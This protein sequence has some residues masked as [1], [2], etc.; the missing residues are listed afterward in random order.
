MPDSF[1]P[2][3]KDSFL[4]DTQVSVIQKQDSFVADSFI[5]E[6]KTAQQQVNT[7]LL[8]SIK[9]IPRF[10]SPTAE[11]LSKQLTG[12]SFSEKLGFDKKAQIRIENYANEVFKRTGKPPNVT[13]AFLREIP[14]S[15][16]EQVVKFID[17]NYFDIATLVLLPKTVKE[18]GKIPIK[19][20]PISQIAQTPLGKGWKGSLK[21]YKAFQTSLKNL[22]LRPESKIFKGMPSNII[23]EPLAPPV[24]GIVPTILPE[25][26][27][28]SVGI[29]PKNIKLSKGEAIRQIGTEKYAPEIKI[30]LEKILNEHPEMVKRKTISHQAIQDMAN[31]LQ[32]TPIVKKLLSMPEGQLAA[33]SLKLRQ[34]EDALI[35]ATLESDLGDLGNN[36]RN[37]LKVRQTGAVVKTGTE[38]GRALEQQKMLVKSQQEIANLINQKI[39]Q[40]KKDPFFRGREG[41][42]LVAGLMELR[43]QTLSKEFD[44]SFFDKAYEFWLHNILSGVWTHTVNV[45]SNAAFAIAKPV[46]KGVAAA[47]DIPLSWFTGKREHYFSEI[48]QQIKGY[49]I[50]FN[51]KQKV[52][53]GVAL[54]SKYPMRAH[55]IGG[56]Q[57]ELVRIPSKL[58]SAEDNFS[59]R[60]IG[61]AENLGRAD[62]IARQEG[63]KG[64]EL[65]ARKNELLATIPENLKVQVNREQLYRTFQDSTGMGELLGKIPQKF[66]RW[67]MPFRNV[68]SSIITKS[69]ERTPLGFV[70]VGAKA[71]AMKSGY[72]QYELAMDLGNATLGTA[73]ATGVTWAYLKG[74]ITGAPPIN[75]AERDLFYAQ[76]KQP[77]S[78][79]VDG[80]Y[81]PYNRIEPYGT[82]AM[83]VVDTIQGYQE[84]EKE[85]PYQK[86]IDSVFNITK[87]LSNK[88][89]LSGMTMFVNAISQPERYAEQEVTRTIGG[90]VPASSL[91]RNI[92][93]MEDLTVR[94]RDGLINSIMADIPILSRKVPAK[95]NV[96]GQEISREPIGVTRFSPFPI[97]NEKKDYVVD[98]LVRLKAPIGYPSQKITKSVKHEGTYVMKLDTKDY[99]KFLSE[100]GQM[101]Y[102]IFFN[103]FSDPRYLM[104]PDE[105]KISLITQIINTTRETPRQILTLENLEKFKKQ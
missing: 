99:R 92:S 103:L 96:L 5:P 85:L 25:Q 95:L 93:R 26:K 45:T 47:W 27:I 84:S 40:I 28:P 14:Y 15:L 9:G 69:V 50:A 55:A 7:E 51:P 21:E 43:K 17:P 12:T 6:P 63:L 71:I 36:I 44:P 68:L 56:K 2:D 41:N 13:R 90:F 24:R 22:S 61:F 83:Q 19:G 8:E 57:G 78:V 64:A 10:F 4:P 91:L 33:E 52:P 20:V 79:E 49:A 34:G 81:I 87:S 98:E 104:L 80:K 3:V 77:Y 101:Q 89:F 72:P 82:A 37:I 32:E 46:E 76:G 39:A 53:E 105:D 62:A 102:T 100:T 67:I 88:S 42:K 74:K 60:M 31:K 48:P 75:K 1:I 29:A 86:A 59:K 38:L 18:I 73:L 11:P 70:K 66:F 94:D 23:E 97:T 30:G 16:T 35:R 58:L 54:G 65:I